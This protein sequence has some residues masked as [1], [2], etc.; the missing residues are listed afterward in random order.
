MRLV[1]L[2]NLTLAQVTS[3][4]GIFGPVT[5]AALKTFQLQHGLIPSGVV[6]DETYRALLVSAPTPPPLVASTDST[7]VDTVLPAEGRGFTTYSREPGGADQ[8]GRASTIRSI[9]DLAEAWA[10]RHASPRLQFGDI[11]RRG[12]GPF[13][14]HASHRLGIDVDIRPLTNNGR[15]EATN[16]HSMSYS[17]ELTRELV[18]LIKQKF[19]NTQI[20]FNDRR[21]INLGLAKA[22]S[23][24]DNHLHVRFT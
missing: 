1:E 17:H 9:M 8:F 20:F 4:R 24:H 12:G 18:E 6:T 7:K 19:P 16:I 15:E 5:E 3:G 11:S 22:L 2:S 14:P 21:L 23:G 13:S 10:G